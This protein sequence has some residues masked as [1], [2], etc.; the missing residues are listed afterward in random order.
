MP[1]IAVFDSGLGSISIIKPIQKEIRVEIIYFA[2]Q[3]NFPYGTKS[4]SQLKKIIESTIKKLQERFEPDVIIVGSNTPSLLLDISTGSKI[5]GVYPPLYEAV[6]T[7]KTK[8]IA[9]LATK[10]VVKSKKLTDYIKKNVP[11]TIKSI[12]INVSPLVELVESGKFISEK[13]FCEKEIKRILKPFVK[14]KIDVATLSSTHLP[15]LLPLLQKIF[16]NVKFLDPGDVIARQVST[17]LQN[18]KSKLHKLQ[19]FASGDT[20]V[21]Q[22]KLWDIGI[23]NKVKSL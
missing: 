5:I 14:E 19:I 10:S 15:F 6:K 21:F 9:I 17:I 12:K 11:M 7:T 22:K 2:D 4:I 23:K 8:T 16:P 13:T 3:E 1:K 18:K 20:Q